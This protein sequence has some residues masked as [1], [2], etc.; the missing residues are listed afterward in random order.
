MLQVSTG[1]FF[2]SDDLYETVHRFVVYTNYRFFGREAIDVGMGKILP[3]QDT[4]GSE[5]TKF[6]CEL[7]ERIE[8]PQGGDAPGLVVSTGGAEMIKDFLA[9]MSFSFQAVFTLD[10]ESTRQIISSNASSRSREDIGSDKVDFL[11]KYFER[12]IR[13]SREDIESFIDL[14]GKLFGVERKVYEGLI[15]SIRRYVSA[16][17]RSRDDLDASYTMMVASV[18]ALPQNFDK[19]ESC[20]ED[21][22]AEA[23]KDIDSA[24]TGVDS[25]V[26]EKIRAAIIKREHL[27]AVRRFVEFSMS[28]IGDSYYRTNAVAVIRPA[29]KSDIKLAVKNAYK[30]RSKY[31][32]QLQSLPRNLQTSMDLQEIVTDGGNTYFSMTGLARFSKYVIENFLATQVAVGYEDFDYLPSVLKWRSI[33]LAPQYWVGRA[34]DLTI[35]NIKIYLSGHLSEYATYL[36]GGHNNFSNMRPILDKID[37]LLPGLAKASQKV[38][39]VAL[40]MH[41]CALFPDLHDR[42]RSF[43]AKYAEVQD[44]PTVENLVLYIIFKSEPPWELDKNIPLLEAYLKNKRKDGELELHPLLES[45]I[46][47]WLVEKYWKVDRSRAIKLMSDGV[48]NWPGNK[49]LLNYEALLLDC[50]DP[51]FWGVVLNL[52][53]ANSSAKDLGYL[54]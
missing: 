23:K 17:Y 53:C 24:L 50:A 28:N 49:D 3:C 11:D 12:S 26:A 35:Y 9:I 41:Y 2:K 36:M 32:H 16:V 19:Y 21:Y 33:T 47:L 10:H 1:K 39:F 31:I 52:N 6:V 45:I 44:V 5:V 54:E 7:T 42:C 15:R 13:S 48:E 4:Y 40:Y 22:D 51:I 30:L 38:P 27:L 29:S 34:D 46:Y 14:C 37:S 25:E 20:W 18:E 8:R 43:A